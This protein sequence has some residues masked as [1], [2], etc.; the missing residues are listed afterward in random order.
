M[1]WIIKLKS[2]ICPVSYSAGN[3]SLFDQAELKKQ[4][5]NVNILKLIMISLII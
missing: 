4:Q 5:C 1:S 2:L 3:L